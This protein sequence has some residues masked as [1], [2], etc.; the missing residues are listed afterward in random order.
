MSS[1]Q[2]GLTFDEK[3]KNTLQKHYLFCH[4]RYFRGKNCDLKF[5]LYEFNN[6]STKYKQ[7]YINL[8]ILN[9]NLYGFDG[10]DIMKIIAENSCNYRHLYD[11]IKFCIEVNNK[12]V[13]EEMF[14]YVLLNY[15]EHTELQRFLR[16]IDWGSLQRESKEQGCFEIF[17]LLKHEELLRELL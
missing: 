11:T 4:K 8:L 17:K 16:C 1:T 12:N 13:L 10:N 7:I 6:L 14:Q 3:S 15:A 9:K 2:N 5:W